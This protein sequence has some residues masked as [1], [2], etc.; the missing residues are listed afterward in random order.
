MVD[1]PDGKR[2]CDVLRTVRGVLAESAGIELKQR[3]CTNV[4]NCSGTCPACEVE[5]EI[6]NAALDKKGDV[7]YAAVREILE[8]ILPGEFEMRLSAGDDADGLELMGQANVMSGV[9]VT[10]DLI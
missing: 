1:D 4:G 3:I 5:T 9:P 8:D 7:D 6:L 2:I 10:E